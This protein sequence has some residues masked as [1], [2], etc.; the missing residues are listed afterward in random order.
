MGILLF[1]LS[2]TFILD[3]SW[4]LTLKVAVL[5]IWLRRVMVVVIEKLAKLSSKRAR[6]ALFTHRFT[7]VYCQTIAELEKEMLNGQSLQGP[8][9]AEHVYFM[10]QE[11]KMENRYAFWQKNSYHLWILISI[12]AKMRLLME[13]ILIL[14][15][16][17]F[18][19]SPELLWIFQISTVRSCASNLYRRAESK[20]YGR[21]SASS[22]HLER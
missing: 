11:N 20:W 8:Q 7:I 3:Q 16:V 4:K 17:T 5:P 6:Y 14:F 10:L 13:K 1:S 9:T 12:Y 2:N 22:S 19:L 21:L 18:C 15:T